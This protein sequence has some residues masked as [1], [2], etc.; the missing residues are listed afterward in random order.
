[1]AINPNTTFTAGSI[2]TAAQ[3]NRFPRGIMAY[4]TTASNAGLTTTVA[5]LGLSLSFT[6]VANRYYK[7]TFAAYAS[8]ASIAS[9]LETYVTDSAN[10]IKGS[11]NLYVASASGYT[12]QLL[13]Y[14]STETAGTVTRKLRG[15][16][17]AGSGTIYGPLDFWVEDIGPA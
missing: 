17:G 7:Y 12:Y 6:A 11:I 10:A 16:C 3:Q 4:A 2:L 9:T 1:M 5:D 8:N 14:I 13:T 15:K